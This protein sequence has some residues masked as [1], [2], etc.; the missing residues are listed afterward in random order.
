MKA[1][2]LTTAAGRRGSTAATSIRYRIPIE[3]ISINRQQGVIIEL[4]QL[5]AS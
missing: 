4:G 2:A 5:H 1:E 3:I